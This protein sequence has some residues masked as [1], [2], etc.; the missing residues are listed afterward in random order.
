VKGVLSQWITGN[1]LTESQSGDRRAAAA[2]QNTAEMDKALCHP[3]KLD[4]IVFYI[5]ACRNVK[6][7]VER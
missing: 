2:T 1:F 6:E 5:T 7:F 3:R 4:T